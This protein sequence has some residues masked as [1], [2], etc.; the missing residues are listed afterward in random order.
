VNELMPEDFF[1]I[2]SLG[3]DPGG[4]EKDHGLFAVPSTHQH[5]VLVTSGIRIVQGQAGSSCGCDQELDQ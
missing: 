4:T 1:L 5:W 3:L 2:H